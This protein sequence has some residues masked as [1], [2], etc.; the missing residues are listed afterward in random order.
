MINGI[1]G[2]GF[3]SGA[4]FV[5]KTSIGD[6]LSGDPCDAWVR[7]TAA[8]NGGCHIYVQRTSRQSDL[9]AAHRAT[10]VKTLTQI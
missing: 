1:H 5:D 3:A 4:L 10:T 6:V 7:V 9:K 8:L 2:C